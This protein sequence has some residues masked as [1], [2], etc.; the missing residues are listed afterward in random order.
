M[1]I[2]ATIPI[3]FRSLAEQAGYLD[4]ATSLWGIAT[5]ISVLAVGILSPLIGAIADYRDMKLKIFGSF[6]IIG[7]IGALGFTFARGWIAFLVLYL[8]SRIGY[9]ACNMLYDSML[10]DVT[11]DDRMDL[12]S[13]HGYAWGYIG[14]CIPFII[15]LVLIFTTPF[16]LSTDTA[17]R[18]SFLI[19]ILWWFLL[20][21][22]LFKNFKQV[23][24][25]EYRKDLVKDSLHR[26]LVTL[27]KI[28]KDKQLFYYVISYFLFIDGV[29][30]II[31][32]ST[33]YGSEIGLDSSSLVFALL[34]TQFIAFPCAIL[35]AK[36]SERIGIIN[37]LRGFIV[38]Y[39]G[40][41]V[42]GYHMQHNWEFW[43]LAA[44][45]GLCQGGIQALSRSYF[46]RMIPK[47]ES[48]EYFGFFDIFGKFAD[49]FGPLLVS[50]S[51]LILHSSR[52]GILSLVFLFVFG[53]VFLNLSAKNA[54]N[55]AE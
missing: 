32:M 45:V 42:F 55:L 10:T 27:K 50:L 37:I 8:I 44:L 46:G 49:F 35:S 2:T 9:A 14:S 33:T 12:L 51:S 7:I 19:T 3:F 31:S 34:M 20:T 47:E 53:L 5:S 1:I 25:L 41:C 38:I 16:G 52:I 43:T 29:Y 26:L 4:Y 6:L 40:I 30:T 48:S 22:P 23:H 28:R 24:C 21:I 11:T 36:L 17:T 15:G 13:A 54:G 18:I 39:M